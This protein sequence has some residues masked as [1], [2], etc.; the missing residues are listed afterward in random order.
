M[1]AAAQEPVDGFYVTDRGHRLAVA[2][3]SWSA[4]RS[5]GPGGQHANTTDSAV[6]ITIDVAATGLSP[7]VTERVM[8]VLGATVV[9]T[10]A[11]SRS[12]WRNRQLAWTEALARFDEAAA[13]PQPPRARTRPSRGARETRLRDK[14]AVAE[15]KRERQR[16]DRDG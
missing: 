6:T 13:P 8:A 5:G 2:A 12:Q 10:S 14:R 1:P 16:P 4:T 15:R 9:A 3:V 11:R 7:I